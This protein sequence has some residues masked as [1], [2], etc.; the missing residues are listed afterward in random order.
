MTELEVL[1][2]RDEHPELLERALAI[3]KNAVASPGSTIKGL[4]RDISWQ[5]IIEYDAAQMKFFPRE[6]RSVPCECYDG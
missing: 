3:E 1:T 4:G 6:R 5:Q 2:L